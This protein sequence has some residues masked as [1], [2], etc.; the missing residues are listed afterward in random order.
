MIEHGT[1]GAG[2]RQVSLQAPPGQIKVWAAIGV[3]TIGVIVAG[4]WR[5]LFSAD[6][7]ATPTGNDVYPHLLAL[8]VV[9]I[10]SALF[11]LYFFVTCIVLPYQRERRIPFDGKLLI[12]CLAVHFVDPMFNYFSP[13]FLQNAYSLNR[14]S[15]ANFIPGYA[16]PSGDAGYVEGILWAAALYGLFGVAAAQGGCWLLGKLRRRFSGIGNITAYGLMFVLFCML[17]LAIENYFVRMQ[18]YVFW[19]AWSPFALWPGELYQFP[20]YETLLAVIYALGFVWL[21]DSR[22]DQG[23]SY[24]ERGVD[25]IQLGPRT[26]SWLSFFAIT[27]FSLVWGIGSY[28]GPFIYTSMQADSFPPLPSYLQGGAFCGIDGKPECPAQYLQKADLDYTRTAER[29]S[30]TQADGRTLEDSGHRE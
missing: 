17:D 24:V 8:R 18:I 10:V 5:W 29:L 7:V 14:G 1:V 2:I 16:S 20:L 27:A 25:C 21:R 9:E 15:W 26:K 12:G 30:T 11:L 4:I 19:G 3:V 23:L 6:F 22:D 28:F 13:S